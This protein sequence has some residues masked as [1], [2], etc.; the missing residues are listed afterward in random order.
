MCPLPS[1]LHISV[2]A[3]KEMSMRQIVGYYFFL[4]PDPLEYGTQAAP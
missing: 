2:Q 4:L 1:L 3:S